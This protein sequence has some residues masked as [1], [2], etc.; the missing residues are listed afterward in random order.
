VSA[1]LDMAVINR[2]NDTPMLLARG[3]E[4]EVELALTQMAAI[5]L[6]GRDMATQEA[7]AR[8]ETLANYGFAD[9][10]NG[11]DK[12]FAFARG[13]AIIPISGLLLNRFGRSWGFVTGYNAIRSQLDAAMADDD[14]TG[15]MYDVNSYGGEVA[16][17]FE[18]AEDIRAARAIKPSV[19]VVDAAAYSAGYALAS[20]AGRMVCIKTGGV[21]SIGVIVTH[22]EYSRA[23]EN[24]GVKVTQITSGDHK[25]DG[26][27]YSPLTDEVR[28][29]I[30]A[31]VDARRTEFVAVVA[32]NRGLDADVVYATEAET[33]RA[34][35]AVTLGL[36]DAVSAPA[37]AA[38]DFL[39]E[40]T[41]SESLAENVN[42]TQEAKPAAT[43]AAPVATTTAAPAVAAAPNLDQARAEAA[44]EERARIDSIRK[45][46]EATSRP[47]L[48]NHLAFTPG[49][50]L[51]VAQGILANA[52]EEKPA[53]AVAPAA[54]SAASDSAFEKA[55]S[56]SASPNVQPDAEGAG[57]NGDGAPAVSAAETILAAFGQATGTTYNS[58]H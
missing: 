1:R 25:A 29:R 37:K 35:E 17:C 42:M 57:G 55:M 51:A 48:A 12:P 54:T 58:K 33:Y 49:M 2:I 26:N 24:D 39:S 43:A 9:G 11:M 32:A 19:A 13:I 14:V 3:R 4:G 6:E 31:N 56:A 52:A 44:A 7:F 47:T 53:T 46:E 5:S 20:A 10:R 18:L 15:I 34:D 22:I 21:G 8:A 38:L 16:G 23:L 28:A 50:T 40:L 41:G 36:I 27:P 30:Q 45:C